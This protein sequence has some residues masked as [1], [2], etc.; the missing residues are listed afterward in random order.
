MPETDPLKA[1]SAAAFRAFSLYLR[2]YFSRNFR[3]VRITRAGLPLDPVGRPLIVCSNHPGWWDP[4]MFIL[5]ASTLLPNRIGFGPMDAA[6][7]NRY[8]VLRKMGVFGID[9]DTRQGAAAFLDTSLRI[10][11]DPRSVLF[12]TAEGAFTDPRRRPVRL[13]AGL[14]HLARRV[15]DAVIL[16]LALEYPLWNERRPEALA[17]FGPPVEA[18]PGRSVAAWTAELE[19]AL[20]QAIDSLAAASITRNPALFQSV[21]RGTTGVGGVYDLWRH[22]AALLRGRRF[23]PSHEGSDP[24]AT[25]PEKASPEE[26]SHAGASPGGAS[27]GGTNHWGRG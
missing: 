24:E 14:A 22:G 13:R 8:G 27:P 9:P 17:H 10:L 23:D 26:A 5:L 19:D 15:P 3:A 6:A 4:A 25:R 1:R 18:V 12:I 2:W 7:L 21:L 20:T 16:P 11:S